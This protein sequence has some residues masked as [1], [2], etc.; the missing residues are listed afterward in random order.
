V[1]RG[2]NASRRSG[3]EI[4]TTPGHATSRGC[5]LRLGKRQ[6]AQI[7]RGGLGLAARREERTLVS[8]QEANPGLD[9]ARVA[10]IAVNRELGAKEGCAQLGNQ[11]LRRI[12][13]LAETVAQIAVKTRLVSCPVAKLM[14]RSTVEMCGALERFEARQADNVL[15]GPVVSLAETFVDIGATAPQK[16]SIVASRSSRLRGFTLLGVV[17]RAGRL[18]HWSTLKTVYSR[19]IGIRRV[20]ASSP[21]FA[22]SL[23][24]GASCFT[25]YTFVPRSP[26]RTWPPNSRACLKVR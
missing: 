10:Q 8:L 17:T 19:N 26:L 23:S 21:S 6:A 14:E 2:S 25:K 15:A 12:G 3:L 7:V 22:V 5:C 16:S 4:T 24:R 1:R 9:V 20:L 18:S 13:T 11:F